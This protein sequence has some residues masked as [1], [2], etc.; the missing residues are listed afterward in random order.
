VVSDGLLVAKPNW[1]ILP[2]IAGCGGAL[3]K[4]VCLP[5][6]NCHPTGTFGATP[7]VR[8]VRARYG[9]HQGNFPD[10]TRG[11]HVL[12]VPCVNKV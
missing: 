11:R 9:C 2:P 1:L 5:G 7:S 10:P 3:L 6:A 8:V 12:E 4:V